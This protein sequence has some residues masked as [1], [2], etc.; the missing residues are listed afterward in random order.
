LELQYKNSSIAVEPPDG[1]GFLEGYASVYGVVD[2]QNE[3]TMPGAFESA[4]KSPR[5]L[6]LLW[7]HKFEQP[8]GKITKLWEDERGLR[9]RAKLNLKTDWG[10]N[11]YE[12]LLA[13]DVNANSIGYQLITGKSA[14]AD[15]GVTDLNAVELHE[16]SVVSFPSNEAATVDNV[17]S[18]VHHG[19][20]APGKDMTEE[21]EAKAGRTLSNVNAQDITALRANL[22]TAIEYCDAV[23]GR[24]AP[25]KEDAAPAEAAPKAPAAPAAKPAKSVYDLTINELLIK[26]FEHIKEIIQ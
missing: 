3:R 20:A 5:R 13:D 18:D 12:A 23:L 14:I 10:R 19:D 25:P 24:A 2:R 22:A 1:K 4:L 6:K 21:L 17:K 15:D 7:Q 26:K 9:F 11:A 8:I 16:I